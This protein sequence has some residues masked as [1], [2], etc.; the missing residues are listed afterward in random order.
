MI[1]TETV[2]DSGRSFRTSRERF[3]SMEQALN[4]H[5]PFI[6]SGYKGLANGPNW[7]KG[8]AYGPEWREYFYPP[9]RNG[10]GQ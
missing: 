7:E 6:M 9:Q 3:I 10:M 5:D 2:H 1:I 4:I 8:E